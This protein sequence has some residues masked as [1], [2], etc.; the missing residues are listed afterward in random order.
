MTPKFCLSRFVMPL[1]EMQTRLGT[2]KDDLDGMDFCDYLKQA[3]TA[4]QELIRKFR[5]C[6]HVF[7]NKATGAEQEDQREQL[8]TL[9]QDVVDKCKGRYYTNSQY[10]KTEEEIQ[11]ETQVLQENYRE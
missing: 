4:I 5:D 8:L 6:Y 2:E 9:V 11:K 10:Q 3:P 7:N 1:T